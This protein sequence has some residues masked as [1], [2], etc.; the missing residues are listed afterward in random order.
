MNITLIF[1][2]ECY[3]KKTTTYQI[4][5]AVTIHALQT[6]RKDK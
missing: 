4:I 1:T 6:N 3:A 5:I 2:D